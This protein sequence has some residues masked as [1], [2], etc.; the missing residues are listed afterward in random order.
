[1][2]K[3]Y[4]T[5][6]YRFYNAIKSITDVI[7]EEVVRRKTPYVTIR[8]IFVVGIIFYLSVVPFP[9]SSLSLTAFAFLILSIP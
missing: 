2:R 5:I 6:C 9:R 1:M 7:W 3:V 4:I 8:I